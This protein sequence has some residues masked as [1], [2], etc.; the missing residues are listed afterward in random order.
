MK[1][2]SIVSWALGAGFAAVAASASAADILCK[3]SSHE[4]ML[5]SS[6][7]V[8]SC[9]A[10]G[11]GNINGNAT[12][13]PFM[14]A[15]TAYTLLGKSDAANSYS[16][17]GSSTNN[18]GGWGSKGDFSFSPTVWD[19]YDTV[20]IGLKF[21]TGNEADEWFVYAMVSGVSSGT[22]DF[23]ENTKAGGSGLSHVNVYAYCSNPDGCA[24]EQVN[25]PAPGTLALLGLAV[26][27][28]GFSLRRT[29]V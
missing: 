11:T 26:L 4:H 24:T 10:A 5:V 18:P 23:V 25:V 22:F 2:R 6:A 8:T 3:D 28:M 14:L 1:C 16:I 29:R 21:G 19:T 17:L 9:L 13:D 12:K 15:Y 7:Y 20:A 27:G